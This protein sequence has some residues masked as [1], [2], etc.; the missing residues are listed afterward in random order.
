MCKRALQRVGFQSRTQGQ[1][2]GAQPPHPPAPPSAVVRGG[3]G[4]QESKAREVGGRKE[5][6]H[7][8]GVL[9]AEPPHT[10]TWNEGWSQEE[11]RFGNRLLERVVCPYLRLRLCSGRL[12]F[13]VKIWSSDFRR[14]ARVVRAPP[15]PR[16]HP[17]EGGSPERT[18]VQEH[19]TR[20]GAHGAPGTGPRGGS[21]RPRCRGDP[22][23]RHR[24]FQLWPEL[25]M[26]LS[27]LCR[28]GA[29]TWVSRDLTTASELFA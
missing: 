15:P 10:Q 5:A 12:S 19:L 1:P 16:R 22:G 20:D 4:S 6:G 8:P 3:F 28:H 25:I 27:S 21:R 18:G 2:P 14:E 11:G 26:N 23:R 9:E 7:R 17:L 29:R 13:Y 24:H